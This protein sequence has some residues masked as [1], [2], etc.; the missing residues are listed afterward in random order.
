[1]S[2]IEK[3]KTLAWF[4]GRP[5]YWYHALA[6]AH[7]KFTPD[8]DSPELRAQATAWA[9]ARAVPLSDALAR[10]GILV[11][12]PLP[13]LPCHTIEEARLR[14]SRSRV[15]MGGAADVNLLYAAAVLS[16][17]TNAIETGVAY[18]WSS[19]ALLSAMAG[20]EGA[21]LVSVDMPYPKKGNDPYVGIV[22]PETL[23]QNWTLVREPDRRGIKRAI[24]MV[25]E[26]LDLVHYDSDKSHAGRRYGYPLLWN[27][28]RPGGVFIS[29]DIEDNF[30]FRE[31][32]ERTKASFAITALEGRYV[33]ISRKPTSAPA[34][35]C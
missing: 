29:D 31:F 25:G 2:M 1:M 32:M 33:G 26:Q 8:L 12:G 5:T 14:M 22:V 24:S 19:L 27:A 3:T 18:G 21:Q 28:L 13:T 17:A 35:M 15:E 6:L 11:D 23:R 7:R 34:D 20:R 9:D 4:L 30:G 10:L 16:G